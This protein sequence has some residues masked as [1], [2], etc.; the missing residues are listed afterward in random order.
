MTSLTAD[1]RFASPHLVE[2]E[3]DRI[4]LR[5]GKCRSCG[6]LSYPLA[7]LCWHCRA[8]AM[9]PV[10]LSRNGKLYAFSVVHAAPKGWLVPYVLGYVDLDDGIRVVGQIAGDPQN[11]RPDMEVHLDIGIIRNAADGTPVYSYVFAPDQ[12][13]G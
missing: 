8:E 6:E 12:G 13:E 3:G 9:E 7:E 1:A 11:L 4:W 2:R 10:R 5:G